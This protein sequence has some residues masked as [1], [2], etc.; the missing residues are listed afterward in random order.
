MKEITVEELTAEV[1]RFENSE[2]TIED[3]YRLSDVDCRCYTHLETEKA[4]AII[5]LNRRRKLVNLRWN[6]EAVSKGWVPDD[7]EQESK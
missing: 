6:S 3:W 4:T 1:K 7:P 5:G 2:K